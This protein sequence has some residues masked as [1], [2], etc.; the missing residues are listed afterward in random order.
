MTNVSLDGD[1][2]KGLRMT[3]AFYTEPKP[4]LVFWGN[5]IPE[6]FK[7]QRRFFPLRPFGFLNGENR[8]V[9]FRTPDG[10][11]CYPITGDPV[12][13]TPEEVAKL[14]QMGVCGVYW[15]R[16]EPLTIETTFGLY[17]FFP[18]FPKGGFPSGLSNPSP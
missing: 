6:S 11:I 5:Y 16:K 2:E 4:D 10:R 13:D 18:H 12:G 9:V 7:K 1:K 14:R 3:S 17:V 15:H 8:Q